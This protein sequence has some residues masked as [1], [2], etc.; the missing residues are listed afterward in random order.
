M[1]VCVCVY[2]IRLLPHVCHRA[3]ASCEED[4]CVSYDSCSLP[5][6][7]VLHF[8]SCVKRDLLILKETYLYRSTEGLE[9]CLILTLSH[10]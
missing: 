8:I 7:T 1:Y 3:V 4:S 5:S 2:V 9:L 6:K 10:I